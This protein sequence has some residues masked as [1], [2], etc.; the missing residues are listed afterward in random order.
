MKKKYNEDY[1]IYE[2]VCDDALTTG[3]RLIS[4]LN[5]PAIE[6]MGVAFSNEGLRKEYKFKAAEGDE[7]IIVGPVMVPDKLILRKD[8]NQT[9]YY[10]VFSKETIKKLVQKFNANGTN[11]RINLDHT[12]QM[13]DA[14]IMEDWIVEDEYFDKSKLYGFNVPVGTYMVKIKIN[15]KKFWDEQVKGL[16]KFGFSVEGVLG[17]KAMNYSIEMDDDNFIDSLTETEIVDI[18]SQVEREMIEMRIIADLTKKGKDKKYYKVVEVL[19]YDNDVM[20][21]AKE[22]DVNSDIFFYY[23]GPDDEK[24]R[25]FCRYMLR[26]D[27]VFSSTDIMELSYKTGYNVMKYKG[28]YNCRHNWVKFRGE[29]IGTTAPT[30][31]QINKLSDK[32]V[33]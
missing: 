33:K 12:K 27:K 26:L 4:L 9:P 2:I 30:N 18:F 25:D 1:P 23:I 5:D 24:T 21:F 17:E 7:Q 28:S 19:D 15:D 16:G 8:E 14:Y 29:Y 6:M 13:V 20:R 10:N 22:R 11:R 31:L 32:A 3:V